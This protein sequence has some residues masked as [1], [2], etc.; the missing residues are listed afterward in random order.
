MSRLCLLMVLWF[1]TPSVW[2]AEDLPPKEQII[3]ALKDHE[4]SVR[5]LKIEYE[6]GPF[7]VGKTTEFVPAGRGIWAISGTKER[8]SMEYKFGKGVTHRSYDGSTEFQAYSNDWNSKT[9]SSLDAV[10]RRKGASAQGFW[11]EILGWRIPQS[12]LRTTDVL[13]NSQNAQW[14]WETNVEQLQGVR[15]AVC[16][17]SLKMPSDHNCDVILAFDPAAD[18]AP[19]FISIL[20]NPLQPDKNGQTWVAQYGISNHSETTDSLTRRKRYWPQTIR[21]YT[22]QQQYQSRIVSLNRSLPISEFQ[23]ASVAPESKA[24]EPVPAIPTIASL[25]QGTVDAR[26]RWGRP[27]LWILVIAAAALVAALFVRRRVA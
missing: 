25:P 8:S 17:L 3:R 7:E 21:H 2:A 24:T 5:H 11:R 23:V 22:H 9:P 16:K 26:P 12:D 6:F 18:W 15:L 4:A 20:S 19:R 10:P 27:S 14:T 1:I 13:R